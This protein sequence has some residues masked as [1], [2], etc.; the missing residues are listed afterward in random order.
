MQRRQLQLP[1]DF[2]KVIVTPKGASVVAAKY[3]CVF[4]HCQRRRYRVAR[5]LAWHPS[6]TRSALAAEPAC[7]LLEHTYL[8]A[9]CK[10]RAKVRRYTQQQSRPSLT[11]RTRNRTR[12]P[13]DQH[14]HHCILNDVPTSQHRP[15]IRSSSQRGSP[16]P[17]VVALAAAQYGAANQLLQ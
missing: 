5:R 10:R 11:A 14:Y 12:A 7:Q 13:P 17:G 9:N 8:P 4:W 2:G 6:A 16:T 15:V 3:P 1:H